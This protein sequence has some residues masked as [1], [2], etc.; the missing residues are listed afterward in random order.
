MTTGKKTYILGQ[1]F[2]SPDNK[3][4]MAINCDI[5]AQYSG[6]G[7][8]LFEIVNLEIRKVWEY[9]PTIWGPVDIKWIDNSTLISR[10]QLLDTLAG[11]I[12]SNYTKI[13]V[14]RKAS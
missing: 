13:S 3:F 9:N 7:F 11:K 12:T 10:N 6:N 1:P 4:I 8:Q 14:K 2:F 5:E